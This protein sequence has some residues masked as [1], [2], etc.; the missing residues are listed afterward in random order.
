MMLLASVALAATCPDLT[1]VDWANHAYPLG[2]ASRLEKGRAEL[3]EYA[4]LGGPHDTH[5]WALKM[6]VY[7]DVDGDACAEAIVWMSQESWYPASGGA[8][9]RIGVGYVFTG[10]PERHVATFYGDENATPRVEDRVVHVG[11]VR[12]RLQAGRFVEVKP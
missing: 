8:G 3:H 12:W 6:V 1:K 9:S 5:L 2:L 10:S 7:G 4:E 11:D